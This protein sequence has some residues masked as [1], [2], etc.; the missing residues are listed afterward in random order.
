MNLN[1]VYKIADKTILVDSIYPRV[2]HLCADYACTEPAELSVKITQEDLVYERSRSELSA[3]AEGS[4]Y[5]EERED[6]L[7]ELAVYRKICEMMPKYD[8]ILFHGSCVAVDGQAYLF[9]APSGTGKSTHTR[10]WR[11]LLGEKAVMVNDDKP[12]IKLTDN[13]AVIYGTPYNG[14]HSLGTNMCAPLRSIC[15][16]SRAEEN[17]ICRADA[18]QVY[19]L[20]LQQVY[21]PADR[22]AL[23]KTLGLVDRL[24][25]SVDLYS[26]G[27]NMDISAAELSYNTMKG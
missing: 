9:T 18:A 26:L 23:V 15:I 8:T 13:G 25:N 20:V 22:E 7:E 12:L 14:K 6:Y 5:V 27:C 2:H 19:P 17:S 1:S 21:R 11:E 4:D 16:I 10:L 24:I 3:Q